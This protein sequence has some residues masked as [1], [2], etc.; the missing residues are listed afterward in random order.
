MRKLCLLIITG[1]IVF[2]VACSDSNEN[3]ADH[4]DES[5]VDEETENIEQDNIDSYE[6]KDEVL[7]IGDTGR[8]IDTLG[9][10]EITIKEVEI[11]DDIAENTP[12]MDRFIEID[13]E[14]EN[15]GD[16]LLDG[17]DLIN[18]NLF[19]EEDRM[20]E[21]RFYREYIN[22]V[23]GEIQP[24]EILT[25][26]ILFEHHDSSFYRLVFGWGLSSVSNELTW[27]FTADE[28]N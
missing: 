16:T 28:A 15:V 22:N 13:L 25:G 14:I 7:S 10:Y 19:D 11:T 5:T 24:G 20:Q 8:M 3:D 18:T 2:T 9:E 12:N 21:N 1:L 27:H 23:E 17:I 26:Q 4:N 6:S